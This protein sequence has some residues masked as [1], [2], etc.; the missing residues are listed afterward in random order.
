MKYNYDKHFHF[1]IE[2]IDNEDYIIER[3]S[4][5]M[6]SNLQKKTF[7]NILRFLYQTNYNKPRLRI[8]KILVN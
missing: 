2:K 4:K 8:R 5:V 1:P 3:L 6:L 7:E